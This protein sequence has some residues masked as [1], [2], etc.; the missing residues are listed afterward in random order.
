MS[1][2]VYRDFW[3]PVAPAGAVTT[4]PVAVTL[5]DERLVVTRLG[6]RA[7]VF[8]DLCIHRGTP[9]SLGW[10]DGEELVCAYH[11]WRYGADGVCTRI[12]SLGPGHSIPRR[13]RV[14]AFPAE[15]RY[16]LI[17]TCLGTPQADIP[18]FPEFDDPEWNAVRFLIGPLE[19]ACGAGR[20]VENFVDQSH[21]PW[22]HEG[23]L[24]DRDHPE[25]HPVSIER[26]GNELRYSWVD[27]SEIAGDKPERIG[28]IYRPFS[29]HLLQRRE[30][31]GPGTLLFFT[32]IP[33]TAKSHTNYLWVLENVPLSA[34]QLAKRK[35][36][37]DVIM[38]QDQRIVEEQ[39]PEELPFDL[40]EE[41]HVKGPDAIAI[42][43]R[44]FM[45]EL[46]AVV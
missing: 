12:P 26:D 7:A 32:A 6:G 27:R 9:L 14:D 42:E 31:G 30:G 44:R 46:G 2:A 10:V 3:H 34:D 20:A 29:I 33:H 22:V 21:F 43:Y 16:G 25:F 23:I 11:G 5:L 24:G 15:E 8:R 35:E 40:S 39:R 45:G 1:E 13:A 41:L 38:S 36:M 4:S 28:R 37:G 18:E 19:W 17:W